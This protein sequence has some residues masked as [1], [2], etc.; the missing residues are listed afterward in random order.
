V[1]RASVAA[2]VVV[3]VAGCAAPPAL[4]WAD[5]AA[6]PPRLAGF[7]VPPPPGRWYRVRGPEREVSYVRYGR[8][9]GV[10]HA[11]Q[12]VLLPL[13]FTYSTAEEFAAALARHR[14][15][16]LPDRFRP[17]REHSE[18]ATWRG[19]PCVRFAV[20][21]RDL[22]A[23]RPAGSGPPVLEMAGF[24]CALGP[25]RALELRY[26]RRGTGQGMPLDRLVASFVDGVRP[27]R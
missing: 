16:P 4:R 14:A 18:P 2:A 7:E 6:P 22:A 17:V 10:V 24:T 5:P 9:P 20:T 1:F 26:S 23:P 12:A 27:V 8:A 11:A 3:L 19:L 25:G 21:V 15:G 13:P